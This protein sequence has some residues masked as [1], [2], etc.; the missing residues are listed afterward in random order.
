MTARA[1]PAGIS[2]IAVGLST[3]MHGAIAAAAISM[4]GLFEPAQPQAI[5]PIEVVFESAAS[6]VPAATGASTAA[7]SGDR[8]DTSDSEALWTGNVNNHHA[9]RDPGVQIEETRPQVPMPEI[10]APESPRTFR[11]AAK[12][13]EAIAA[14]PTKRDASRPKPRQTPAK[15]EPSAPRVATTRIRAD[16]VPPTSSPVPMTSPDEGGT[17]AQTARAIDAAKEGVVGEASEPLAVHSGNAAPVYPD[18]ARR[19]GWEGRVVLRVVVDATG[20]PSNVAIGSS[21]GH[22][23]LDDAAVA[24]VGH[25]RF[26]PARMAGVPI[27]ASVD[28]PVAFRLTD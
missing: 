8:P 14:V 12:A 2:P 3:V 28:V 7:R 26:E 23:M 16:V 9:V 22:R 1:T 6:A 27:V 24:A 11:E 21:S 17:A 19:R 13:S 15:S 4:A 20:V 18:L 25:W 5:V 10:A